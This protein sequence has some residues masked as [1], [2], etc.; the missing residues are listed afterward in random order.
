MDRF[1]TRALSFT[2]A[3][4]FALISAHV[5]HFILVDFEFVAVV[6]TMNHVLYS[7]DDDK[8]GC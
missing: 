3:A 8:L 2:A 4:L 5:S 7:D 1:L 6:S